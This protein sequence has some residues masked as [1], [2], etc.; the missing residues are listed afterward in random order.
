MVVEKYPSTAVAQ[1]AGAAHNQRLHVAT[2]RQLSS[3]FSSFVHLISIVAPGEASVQ[4]FPELQPLAS[5]R[6]GLPCIWP[7]TWQVCRSLLGKVGR[8]EASAHPLCREWFDGTYDSQGREAVWLAGPSRLSSS[9]EQL[10]RLLSTVIHR[11]EDIVE[12]QKERD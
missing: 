9:A 12:R 4:S 7:V 6:P 11:Q 8:T 5:S 1:I 3:P 2:L 10:G